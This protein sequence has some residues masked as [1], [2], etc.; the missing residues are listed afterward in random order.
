LETGSFSVGWLL[1]GSYLVTMLG[2]FI[3]W[4]AWAVVLAM[5]AETARAQLKGGSLGLAEILTGVPL[6]APAVASLVFR[7]GM[8]VGWYLAVIG[9]L[10]FLF[11]FCLAP[12]ATALDGRP[13]VEA[14]TGAARASLK[15]PLE[16]A[17]VGPAAPFATTAASPGRGYRNRAWRWG[18]YA[19][20]SQLDI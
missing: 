18:D 17:A 3:Q 9:A 15:V 14:F 7:A 8:A 20:G 11:F 19:R 12:A 16:L 10:V 2:D 4:T 6:G 1:R 5:V 13:L